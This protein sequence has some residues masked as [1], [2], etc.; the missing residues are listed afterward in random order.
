MCNS[1][2]F[3]KLKDECSEKKTMYWFCK[4]NINWYIHLE[5]A[6][7]DRKREREK[8]I[9]KERVSRWTKDQSTQQQADNKLNTRS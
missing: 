6:P 3:F 7:R 2:T 8:E 4:V 1:Q 9:E 5:Q